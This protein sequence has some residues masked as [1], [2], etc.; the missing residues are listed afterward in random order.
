MKKDFRHNGSTGLRT[1][2]IGVLCLSALCLFA[3]GSHMTTTPSRP[4]APT[5]QNGATRQRQQPKSK[6]Y[7]L[8]S[9]LLRKDSRHPDAQVVVGNVI[10]R[11]D[12]IYMYCDSAYYY[13]QLGAFEAFSNVRMEQGDTL[14]LYGDHLYY[15]GNT[16]IAEMRINVRMEDQSTTLLTDSLN[17]DRLFSLGYYFEGGTMMDGENVLTSDWG[18]Y[19]TVTKQ[20]VFNYNVRLVNRQFVLT[21]DTLQY[22]SATKL[23]YIVGPSDI[24]SGGTKIYS[25][26]GT[27]NTETGHA[28]LYDRSEMRNG[29]R[30]LTGDTLFYSRDEQYGEAFTDVFMIDTINKNIMKGEYGYYN[31]SLKFAF[32]TVKALAIDYSQ[33]DSLFLHGDTLLMETFNLYTDSL[34]REMRAYH[35]VRFYR[36]DVQGVSD[37]MCFSSIDSCLTMYHDPVIWNEDQQLLGEKILIYMNDSTVDWSHIIGQ[38]LS[39][40]MMDTAK[41]NQVTGKEMKAYFRDGKMYKTEVIGTVRLVYYPLDSDSL[42]IGMNVSETSQLDVYLKDQK[43]DKMIMYPQSNGTLYPLPQAPPDKKKLSNF[44]W[45]DYIRPVDK[46]DIWVWRDKKSGDLLKKNVRGP[47]ALPN[48][49]LFDNLPMQKPKDKPKQET[50]LPPPP[51]PSPTDTLAPAVL[52]SDTLLTDTLV[53]AAL[54]LDTLAL[55]NLAADTLLTDTLAVDTTLIENKLI[56]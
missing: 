28:W 30:L 1:L 32:A 56:E 19:N 39:V 34:Y 7:L 41:Y 48:Q 12:S 51:Q 36:T 54:P 26:L 10:F 23:A 14:F 5:P 4:A 24:V 15:D 11:H 3:G 45:L 22:N 29:A 21:S 16:Q 25:E 9:D 49:N 2:L 31:D 40:E 46:Y 38:A 6:V 13:D 8:H 47:V 42:I 44:A 17:Y 18:E 27:Y 55:E 35:K 33:G 43:V 50:P 52:P 53:R 37:S 20:S